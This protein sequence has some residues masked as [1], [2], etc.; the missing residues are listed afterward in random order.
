MTVHIPIHERPNIGISDPAAWKY[1][2]FPRHD[3][4]IQC[5]N[6]HYCD[7]LVLADP[8]GNTALLPKLVRISIA[9][10]RTPNIDHMYQQQNLAPEDFLINS[11]MIRSG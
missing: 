3:F 7:D 2:G 6:L 8:L 4:G 1:Q 11:K 5:G 10:K 9:L